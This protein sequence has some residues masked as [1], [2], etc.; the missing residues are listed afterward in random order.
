MLD[1]CGNAYGTNLAN[2]FDSTLAYVTQL[3]YCV[4]WVRGFEEMRNCILGVWTNFSQGRGDCLEL[5]YTNA[6]LVVK[7]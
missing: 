4:A 2:R 3:V 7:V 6:S 1:E 5:I